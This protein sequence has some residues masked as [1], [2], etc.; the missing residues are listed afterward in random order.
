MR[1]SILSQALN[2]SM[3]N[4]DIVVENQEINPVT[5]ETTVQVDEVL[6]E[7]SHRPV[8]VGFLAACRTV[9]AGQRAAAVEAALL[10]GVPGI[11]LAG[12]G[13][14]RAR[15]QSARHCAADRF[16]FTHLRPPYRH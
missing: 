12:L 14:D 15:E 8:N 6:E 3:E 11:G 16:E 13:L 10:V 5:E 1:S 2:V 7:A 9:R 4:D